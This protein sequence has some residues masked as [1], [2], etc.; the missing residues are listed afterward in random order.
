MSCKRFNR[1]RRTQRRGGYVL[2]LVAMMLFGLFAMAALVTD[3]GF[4]R[5]AQRQMQTAVDAAALEGLR[6]EG[7]TDYED[8]QVAAERIVTWTFEDDLDATTSSAGTVDSGAVVRFSAGAGASSLNA[9]QLM[10]VDA[11]HSTVVQRR[12][13]P[14]A[15]NRFSVA[16]QRGGVVDVDFDLFVHGSSVA[17]LFARG[18][19]LDRGRIGDGIATGGVASAEQRTAVRVGPPVST[20]PGV[21]PVAF[22]LSDWGASP[23]NPVTI[24]SDISQ[25]VSI[26]QVVSVGSAAVPPPEG[27]CVVYEPATSR[28]VGFGLVG[29]SVPV[30]GVVASR[31]ATASLSAALDALNLLDAA[32]RNAVLNANSSLTHALNAPVLVRN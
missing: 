19:L 20:L 4:A 11:N 5:L 27:Y 14:L 6:G 3:L 21:V 28:V 18:S 26:G 17:Y 16:V 31:N 2:V 12:S 24:T 15:I 7:I 32:S 13:S 1:S 8:R 22:A 23:S 9:S 10:T 25:G 29:Q 30:E